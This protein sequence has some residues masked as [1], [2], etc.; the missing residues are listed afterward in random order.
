MRREAPARQ[1]PGSLSQLEAGAHNENRPTSE[2]MTR[3]GLHQGRNGRVDKTRPGFLIMIASHSI[4]PPPSRDRGLYIARE[5][6][7]EPKP[8]ACQRLSPPLAA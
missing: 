7:R 8:N 2:C 3:I 1:G 4:A 6:V 5:L